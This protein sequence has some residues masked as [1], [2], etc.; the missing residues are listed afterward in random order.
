[1]EAQQSRLTTEQ[2]GEQWPA[3]KIALFKRR[4][5]EGFDLPDE[6]Y[7]QWLRQNHPDDDL[8]LVDYF[9]DVLIATPVAIGSELLI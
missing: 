2:S 8:S 1:M 3:E 5:E 4:F 6:E 9:P 7:M